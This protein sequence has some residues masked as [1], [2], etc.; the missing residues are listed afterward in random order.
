MG[1]AE[2]LEVDS[3]NTL[4]L[5]QSREGL[6]EGAWVLARRQTGGRGRQGRSWESPE[7]NLHASTL[8]RLGKDDPPASTLSLAAAVAIHRTFLEASDIAPSHLRIKWP[9]DLIAQRRQE[10]RKIAGI[11][12]EREG[13]VIVAG[14]GA[15]LTHAPEL[16]GRAAY[17]AA[18]FGVARN[19]MAFCL[20][21]ERRFADELARW[22]DRG[23][24][25]TRRRWLNRSVPIGTPLTVHVSS[26]E[27]ASG[28]FDGLESDGALRLRHYD[29]GVEIVRA[30]DVEL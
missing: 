26:E 22:R 6:G 8:V 20:V 17:C 24:A 3:T 23:A 9:N 14:F 18:D 30:G 4:L 7:G 11:L 1:I 2:Y 13:D 15:N 5:R 27:I 12:L 21:L 29:G 19:P 28:T 25:D 16:P 10:W